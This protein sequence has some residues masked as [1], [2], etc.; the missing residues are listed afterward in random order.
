MSATGLTPTD[1]AFRARAGAQARPLTRVADRL[2]RER[3]AVERTE[4]PIPELGVWGADE[5]ILGYCLRIVEEELAGV[6]REPSSS[7]EDLLSRAGRVALAVRTGEGE[8]PFLL[9]ERLVV[10]ALDELAWGE[11]RRRL[12]HWEGT[13]DP[14]SGE[15]LEEFIAAHVVLGYSLRVVE[16]A[17]TEA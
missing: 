16:A 9:E 8:A 11:V 14:A 5:M 6:R 13:I 7:G 15:Q 4:L 10:G 17:G 1:L 2:V 3:M 12:E